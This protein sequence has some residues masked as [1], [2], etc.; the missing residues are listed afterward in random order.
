MEKNIL[1]TAIVAGMGLLLAGSAFAAKPSGVSHDDL[2][3]DSL[4]TLPMDESTVTTD[5]AKVYFVQIDEAEA[6]TVDIVG[7]GLN[8]NIRKA[9]DNSLVPNPDRVYEKRFI[10]M[11]SDISCGLE[12]TNTMKGDSTGDKVANPLTLC[13]WSTPILADGQYAMA[14]N[15][16][17]VG[18]S[19]PN[20]RQETR[21]GASSCA[22]A[23]DDVFPGGLPYT[24]N[25]KRPETNNSD[26]HYQLFNIANASP[27]ATKAPK[28]PEPLTPDGGSSYSKRFVF[29]DDSGFKGA[30]TWYELYIWDKDHKRITS[31]GSNTTYPNWFKLGVDNQLSCNQVT[32]TGNR[33]CTFK[34]APGAKFNTTAFVNEIN[35][36]GPN[37]VFTWYVQG[38]NAFG[39]SGWSQGG[40]FTK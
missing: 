39:Y 28:R 24:S 14:I 33:E 19:G 20:T 3:G 7:A 17:D 26:G 8:G 40:T 11:P 2:Y 31:Y 38:W 9:C 35:S 6:Y 13:S 27:A 23:A 25:H 29:Q 4:I 12:T 36:Y 34:N 16:V 32:A 21:R 18:G 5:V 10:L 30:A 15:P 22:P 1:N 37:D